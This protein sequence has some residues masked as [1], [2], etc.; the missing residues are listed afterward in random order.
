[1]TEPA[2]PDPN[3]LPLDTTDPR[4]LAEAFADIGRQLA[5]EVDT[6]SALEAVIDL[7]LER[8][9]GSHW[10]SIARARENRYTT[11]VS[12]DQVARDADKLQYD[13]GA[14]PCIDAVGD[15]TIFVSNDLAQEH[16][17]GSW[18]PRVS[19]QL[20]VNS[21]LSVRLVVDVGDDYDTGLRAGLNLYSSQQ[22]AFSEDS[23]TQATLLAAHAAV[24]VTAVVYR[25]QA[26]HMQDALD[27]NRDI[28]VAIGVLMGM[29][30]LTR[31]HAFDLLR[32]ASQDSSRKLRDIA[33]VVAETGELNL[34]AAR[35]P[36][37]QDE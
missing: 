25:E 36:P 7:A 18:G 11:M 35:L 4:A 29:H 6:K 8:V 10:A 19:S 28:G 20:G 23:R 30:K 1:M 15:D 21:V 31:E 33:A 13:I 2:P 27:S 26:R 24:G 37:L 12:R 34:P 16:R 14:G 9:P 32:I 22:D 5:A 3:A 17:W